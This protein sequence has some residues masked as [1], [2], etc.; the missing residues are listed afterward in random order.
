[1][2][3][4]R[5][6]TDRKRAEE[7]LQLRNREL[8]LLNQVSRTLNSTLDPDQVFVA[9]LEAMRDLMGV[10][11]CSIWLIDP[12]TGEMVCQQA[13][14][15]RSEVVRGWRLAPGE[16]IADWVARHGESVIVP[17]TRED[18]RHCKGVGQQIGL[19]I[20]SLLSIPLKVRQ[21]VIGV[22]EAVDTEAGR[23]DTIH[24]TSLEPLAASAA[25]AIENARMYKQAQQEIIERKRA[26][27][28]L[29]ESER[30]YRTT[31]DAMGDAIHLV[32]TDLRFTLVNRV[33]Q[34]RAKQ[35]GSGTPDYIGR[36]I[37]E[38]FPSLADGG[39]DKLCAEYDQVFRTGETLITEESI[40]FGDTEFVTEVRK[41]PILEKERVTQVVTVIRDITERKRAEEALR[42][43]AE[44]LRI[45]HEIDSAILAAHSLEEI[46]EATLHH[47][48]QL[49][50]CQRA[51]IVLS[52]LESSEGTILAAHGRGQAML[53]EGNRF[54]LHTPWDDEIGQR[55]I[56]VVENLLGF[57]QQTVQAL[58]DEGLCSCACV[59]LISQDELI[60]SLNLWT[61]SPGSLALEQTDIAWE[62]ADS[63][64]I[65]IQHTQLL[66]SVKQQGEHLRALTARLAET[67][68]NERRQMARE[69]HDQVGQNLTA[70]GINLNLVRT[71]MPEETP[72]LAR[73][74]LDDSLALV[75]E[76]VDRTRD[77]MANLRPPM[78]DD[79]GLVAT[80]HWYSE[81]FASWTGV[82]VIVHGK[83]PVPRLDTLAENALFRIAQ[84]ALT[85]VCKHAQA[86]QVTV[87][88][89]ADDEAVSLVVADD[90]VGFDPAQLTTLD[91]RRG[92]GLVIMTE[93][94]EAVGGSC[95]IESRPQH[96]TRVIVEVAR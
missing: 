92:W 36:T 33:Y 47:I 27:D 89:T 80:L 19:E 69:L 73:S 22:L 38:V 96:G 23:F 59:P 41:I 37:F 48:R 40:T 21:D 65:A 42:E 20:R 46:A 6:I 8:A 12:A 24:L 34:Q 90:G 18:E 57:P 93:R 43:Q 39:R 85:N 29:R 61:E 84:E 75:E 94:A 30:K 15:P 64:A 55:E 16:G 62:V 4:H 51:S 72:V 63:L 7:T 45:L 67:E 53:G 79:Y 1:M 52:D 25:I 78:L 76:T 10:S 83:E 13:A 95:R 68:E 91:G 74:R 2:A 87:T 49:V 77:V 31:L 71:H 5:D 88:V 81:R 58:Q 86:T 44:R 82:S 70:L 32:G 3:S 11:A 56:Y 35:F 60:G 9:I 66:E 26:E 14:G 17:D 28:A 50:P 54:P